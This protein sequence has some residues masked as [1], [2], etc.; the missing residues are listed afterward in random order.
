MVL[1]GGA[2]QTDVGEL[3]KE[4]LSALSERATEVEAIEVSN[5]GSPDETSSSLIILRSE[6]D[7]NG[8]EPDDVD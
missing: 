7:E 4:K 1:M 3:L 8:I 5:N 2:I 6:N